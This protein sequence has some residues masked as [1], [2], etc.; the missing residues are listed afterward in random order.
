MAHGVPKRKERTR[1]N[2]RSSSVRAAFAGFLLAA[3][4]FAPSASHAVTVYKPT[5]SISYQNYVYVSWRASSSAT[6][7]RVYRSTTTNFR[8]AVKLGTYSRSTRAVRDWTAKL[9]VKYYYW[10]AYR[11]GNT[12]YYSSSRRD[13]GYRKY[14]VTWGT[15]KSGKTTYGGDKLWLWARVNGDC[16]NST[17]LY[18]KLTWGGMNRWVKYRTGCYLGYFWSSGSGR[19][20]YTLKTGKNV[21]ATCKGTITWY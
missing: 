5:A 3:A 2:T 14:T 7:Y 9:G 17:S 11:V 6:Q 15:T 1:V 4:A 16:L 8:D 12:F 19:G 10:V 13:Y 18:W 20:T 21:T